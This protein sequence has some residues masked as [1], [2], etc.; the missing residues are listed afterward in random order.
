MTATV[1]VR[2]K[3]L[4]PCLKNE[5]FFVKPLSQGDDKK[6]CKGNLK[7][8][9]RLHEHQTLSS[10]RRF[11]YFQAYKDTVPSDS[12]DVALSSRYDHEKELFPAKTDYYYQA[13]TLGEQTWRRL[14]NTR[15]IPPVPSEVIEFGE[16]AIGGGISVPTCQKKIKVPVMPYRYNSAHT[17]R[18]TGLVE[19]KNPN[20]ILLMHSSHHSSQTNPGFSRQSLD[21]NIFQY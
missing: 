2:N 7:T 3:S 18:I 13:E 19:R 11:A 1:H 16:I 4:V 12:L 6:R 20:N 14:R 21:G 17:V 10:A 9:E 5:G 8:Y 15:D